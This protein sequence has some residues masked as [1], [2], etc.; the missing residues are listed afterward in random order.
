MKLEHKLVSNK[1]VSVADNIDPVFGGILRRLNTKEWDVEHDRCFDID[2]K[3]NMSY[4]PKGKE[5]VVTK[6]DWDPVNRQ[7]GKTGRLLKKLPLE[8]DNPQELE[9]LVH[10]IASFFIEPEVEIVSGDDI[11]KYYHHKTY[12][13]DSGTLKDSCMKHDKCQTFFRLYTENPNQV[14]LAILK[15]GD[16]IIARALL[17]V[18]SSGDIFMDRVYY[19]DEK[20]KNIMLRWAALRGYLV[21]NEQRASHEVPIK[22]PDGKIKTMELTVVLD[23][24][25]FAEYPYL[26]TLQFLHP[27]ASS[28]SNSRMVRKLTSTGGGYEA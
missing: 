16:K 23:N 3:G 19:T 25:E 24:W 9:Q 8:W 5:C 10:D 22:T 11:R 18:L 12:A 14:S 15:Q 4:L 7:S 6:G 2:D 28:I 27:G 1:L 17:W 26:D 13:R 20:T 21:K